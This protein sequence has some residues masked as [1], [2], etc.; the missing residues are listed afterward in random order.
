MKKK[1]LLALGLSL[2]MAVSV[3]AGSSPFAFAVNSDT[4]AWNSSPSGELKFEKV[5]GAGHN[6]TLPREDALSQNQVADAISPDEDVRVIIVMDD[7]SVVSSN[8]AAV[9]SNDTAQEM[10][11]I[12]SGQNSVI[13][14]IEET[15]LD[16]DDLSVSYQYSW[17]VN[18][19]AATVPY[20]K[21]DEIRAVDGVSKVVMQTVYEPCQS[22]EVTTDIVYPRTVSDGVM[23][24]REDTWAQG[25]KGEGMTIAVIDTG[26]D[27]DHQ[28]FAALP[29]DVLTDT[30]LTQAGI[31]SV[32]TSL[33]AY[34]R[35]TGLTAA[36]LY[37]STK[38]AYGFNYVDSSLDVTHDNDNQGDHGTHVSGIAA[39]NKVDGSD[40]VGVAPNAQLMVMKV[41]GAKGGAYTEDWLAGLEDALIL[42]ADV[43]NMS[44][45]SDAGFTTD[46][47][48]VNNVFNQV[49]ETG[50]VLCISAGN[51]TTAGQGNVFGLNANL[52]E[53]PDNGILGIPGAFAN[54]LS[55]ASVDN[56]YYMSDYIMV[57]EE[58]YKI[59]YVN[60]GSGQNEPLNTLAGT[61][62]QVVA[63]PGTGTVEDFQQVDVTGKIALVERGVIAFTEKCQNA[64]NAGAVA[65]LV[66]NNESGTI[67]MDMTGS[68]VTIP[69]AS[70]TMAD[71]AYI[72]S[73]LEGNAQLTVAVGADQ[74]LVASD[75]GSQMSSFSSWGVTP[76][77]TLEPDITAPG[78]NIYS[79][80]DGGTYGLMSGTSMAS[81]NLAGVSALVKQYVLSGTGLGYADGANTNSL[82]RAL[83]MSTSKPLVFQDQ[84]GLYYSPRSQGSGLANAYGAVTTQAYLTVD[85]CDVPKVELYDDP[86]RTGVYDFSFNVTNFGDT[87]LFYDL[88]TVAQTEGVIDDATTGYK[89]M[90]STPEALAAATAEDSTALVPKYDVTNNGVCD[91]HDAYWIYRAAVAGQAQ[92]SNWTDVEFRYDTNGDDVVTDADVQAYLDALVGLGD[93]DLS[94]SVM[95]VDAGTTQ[96][97]NVNVTLTDS[98]KEYFATNYPNGGYVEGYTFLSALNAGGTDLSLPYL[99]FYGDWTDAPI[100]DGD[101]DNTATNGFYWGDDETTFYSQY[102]SALWTQV[103]TTDGPAS[104]LP[105]LNP[106]IDEPFDLSHV[107]LSPNGDG[108]VD[109]LDDIY[110]SLLRS[111]AA[112]NFT[113]TNADTGEVYLD[114]TVTH[115]SKTYYD[116]SYGMCVPYLYSWYNTPYQ[117]TDTSGNTLPNNTKL[118][119][120]I[121]ATLDYAG[122][123]P[124]HKSVDIT[125][126]TAAPELLSAQSST[127][128]NGERLLTL[129]F[130]DNVSVA[131]VFLCDYDLTTVYA[132]YG[133]DDAEATVDENGNLVWTQTY[134]VTD[135]GLGDQFGIGL[136]DYAANE[137]YWKLPV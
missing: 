33:N 78:G 15:V 52:T 75:T 20:G 96:T 24:G 106:Y 1:R 100:F 79:T 93:T 105:G 7:A 66:Y 118:T 121:A 80:L 39:A 48:F 29:D 129:T 84:A 19:V 114:E 122:A 124:T 23:I 42:G 85:G 9:Y 38:V 59:A 119:L 117:L 64:Q 5:D 69:C 97:V 74:A 130:Q 94:T 56:N 55:V 45:G 91:S 63:V 40:V 44:L 76:S 2:S 113:Y 57:G 136:G 127:G 70:I 107:S 116:S 62:Y 77:L 115:V 95:A 65:C 60:G 36:D 108:N 50:T 25:Y 88:N 128:T 54:A 101:N 22:D 41:F 11:E 67:T 86:T 98:D 21:L 137:A 49:A 125:V 72:R 18:G 103:Q 47:E 16:G 111:A 6:L 123:Q 89:F 135:L 17:L 99:G 14:D 46:E 102:A 109:Y 68:S 34:Q 37:R 35:Y 10:Q 112:L 30:S 82:V 51:A 126:D 4:S 90:S 61:D 28:N 73:A 32:L 83:M 31:D 26:L 58:A 133:A 8:H 134:D 27:M 87:T 81:P 104:W 71:G 3:T 53:N 92:D 120:D 110:V 43:V 12:K 132:V 131:A 13:S